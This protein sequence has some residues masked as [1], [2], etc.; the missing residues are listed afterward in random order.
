[1]P[2]PPLF[3]LALAL[4]AAAPAPAAGA[5]PPGFLQF[6]PLMTLAFVL[7][8]L[9]PAPAAAAE[10]PGWLDLLSPE[11]FVQTMAQTGIMALRTVV[12]IKYGALSVDLLN[13]RVT[14]TDLEIWPLPEWDP[15]AECRI[16][17]DRLTLRTNAFDEPER[18]RLRLDAAGA[19]APG[20]CLPPDTRWMLAAAGL[21][22]LDVPV[23]AVD[24]DYR[25]PGA[26]AAVSALATVEGLAS[27]TLTADF[28]YLWLDAR[29]DPDDPEPVVF[30]DHARLAVENLG[31]WAVAAAQLPPPFTDPATATMV[32]PGMIG[33]MIGE[34]NR[35][36]DPEAAGDP[37]A[38][39]PA[40]RA[41]LDSVAETW[42][43]F[44]AAPGTL[45]LE[46][47]VAGGGYLDLVAFER[48]PRE[49][50]ETLRPVLA[51]A[52]VR[53]PDV[54]PAELLARALTDAAGL[55]AE[56][57]RR[58]GLALA[59][60]AGAPRN[61]AAARDLLSDLATE[62]GEAALALSDAL[63]ASAPEDAYRWALRAGAM[64][65]P[66]AMGRLDRLET[67]LGLPRTL[68]LQGE[69]APLGLT[70]PGAESLTAIRAAAAAHLLGQGRARSYQVAAAW[71]LLGQAAGDREA[72]QI[73]EDLA[74][75]AR[76]SGT[77]GQASWAAAEA[78]ASRAATD[79]WLAGD[80]PARLAP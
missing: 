2:R 29:V 27:A 38:L 80:L 43:A 77:E 48:D 11:R 50:F 61:L 31:G 47:Q 5:E 21:E 24:V 1:M 65:A 40:Q 35:E 70:G 9:A 76:R 14:L 4:P 71:A 10:S 7:P 13:G 42:P 36:A 34:A 26:E 56:E 12:D 3:A 51:T 79:L 60:G 74:I 75:R 44:L 54:L 67:A 64:G 49:V 62:D 8:G 45:V 25:V 59:R 19:T 23:L 28:S 17:V 78:E 16:A 58:A 72:G 63:A 52:P 22:G 69:V 46:T 30:L 32:V 20:I 39:S 15:D 37:S 18:L 53:R 33:Q 66:G 68:A 41:F 6:V 57:R 73:L 55:S